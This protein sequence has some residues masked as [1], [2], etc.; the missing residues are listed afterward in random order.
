MGFSA[1]LSISERKNSYVLKYLHAIMCVLVH[2]EHF[3]PM[4]RNIV[5]IFVNRIISKIASLKVVGNEKVGGSGVCQTVP[6]CLG[7]RRSGF[8]SRSI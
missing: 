7:P 5:V 3:L 1:V 2:I 4:D 6:I 8:V